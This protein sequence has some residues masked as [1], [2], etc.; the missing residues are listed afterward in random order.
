MTFTFTTLAIA[1]SLGTGHAD[2]PQQGGG[3]GIFQNDAVQSGERAL[4]QYLNGEQLKSILTPGETVDYP[5][6]LKPGQ[7]LV[8]DAVSESFDPALEIVDEAG[9]VQSMNDD[10]Y[11]GDQRPLLFWRC[12]KLG[13]YTLR[14][15][16]F[17]NKAGGEVRLRHKVY[18][19]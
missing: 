9:K 17:Q 4:S 18:D 8:A 13:G 6:D 11:P 16:S 10:R 12:E 15:R 19:T 1:L 14:V 5:I 3:Q 7:V 2:P